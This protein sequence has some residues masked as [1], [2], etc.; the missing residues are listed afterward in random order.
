[1]LNVSLHRRALPVV[2]PIILPGQETLWLNGAEEVF[3]DYAVGVDGVTFSMPAGSDEV[4][5]IRD[6]L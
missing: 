6:G 1:M 5:K 3:E 2:P 4:I